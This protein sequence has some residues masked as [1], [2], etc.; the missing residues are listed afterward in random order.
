MFRIS[1]DRS[2]RDEYDYGE[3]VGIGPSVT[4][5]LLNYFPYLEKTICPLVYCQYPDLPLKRGM[6]SMVSESFG[7][8]QVWIWC[9]R[10]GLDSRIPRV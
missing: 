4:E 10:I 2:L 8:G 7:T 5:K 9:R 1:T 6:F 3:N